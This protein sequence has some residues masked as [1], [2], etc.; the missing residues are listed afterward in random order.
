[1][2]A[3]RNDNAPLKEDCCECCGAWRCVEWYHTPQFHPG[4]ATSSDGRLRVEQ[5]GEILEFPA[6]SADIW[7][8]ICARRA[9][10]NGSV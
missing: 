8:D 5:D 1:M 3:E 10:R 6:P 2:C 9:V 7:T 4:I